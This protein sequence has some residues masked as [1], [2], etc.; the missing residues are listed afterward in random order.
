MMLN[1]FFS[2]TQAFTRLKDK[3]SWWLPLL[4]TV[5][6]T[7]VVT[8]VSTRYFDWETQ[9]Q[10]VIEQLESRN[11]TPEQIEQA[12][13]QMEKFWSSPIMRFG[14]PVVSALVM[15]LA[16]VFVLAL[17]YNLAMPLLGS[18]GNYLRSLSV[19]CLASLVS[20]PAGIVKVLLVLLKRSA[21]VSTSL[22]LAAPNIKSGFLQVLFSR[23]DPFAFWQL[24]LMALGLKVVFDLKGPKSYLMVFIVWLAF[25]LIFASL[26]LFRPQQ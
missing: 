5:L 25:T 2:P 18:T 19:V 22:L 4:I 12:T 21:E 15:Q 7:L 24:I 14:M 16:A 20:I 3:P 1:V 10:R 11:M 17:I 13:A 9:R 6:V 26:G 23:V 8:V